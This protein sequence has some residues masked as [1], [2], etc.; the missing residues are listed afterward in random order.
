MSTPRAAAHA[1]GVDE[2]PLARFERELQEKH[3]PNVDRFDFPSRIREARAVYI[4]EITSRDALEAAK[5]ADA[6]ADEMEKASIKL[7]SDRERTEHVR[8][9]IVGIVTRKEP[10]EYRHVGGAHPFHEIDAWSHKANMCLLTFYNQMNGIPTEEILEGLKGA[11][12]IGAPALPTTNATP[13]SGAI[14]K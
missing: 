13:A 14:A 11:R 10:L 12:T 8:I 7:M 3:G 6:T 4:K 5:Y 9:S 1:Q 2:T